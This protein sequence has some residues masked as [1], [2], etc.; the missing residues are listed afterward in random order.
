M[1]HMELLHQVE[2]HE[3]AE[4]KLGDGRLAV[5]AALVNAEPDLASEILQLFSTDDAAAR[6][7]TSSSKEANC[8]PAR[9]IAEGHAADILSRVRSAAHGFAG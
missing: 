7:V 2:A 4:K 3:L 5:W 6:W 9:Q 1:S 8:S